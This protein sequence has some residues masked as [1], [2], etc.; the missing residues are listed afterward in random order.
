MLQPT[1]YDP[2]GKTLTEKE[3]AGA[4]AGQAWIT[5]VQSVYPRLREA[6]ARLSA[7]GIAFFD[8]TAVF[9]DHAEDIYSDLC[10]FR[11][12]GNEILADA[13]AQAFLAKALPR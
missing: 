11:E 8:A 2:A 9:N 4:G 12:H 1:L 10:H 5:G 6:G 7:H 3:K 13:I